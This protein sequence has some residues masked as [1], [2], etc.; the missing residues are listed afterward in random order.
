MRNLAAAGG[1]IVALASL[2]VACGHRPP[3]APPAS[4]PHQ[5]VVTAPNQVV[6]APVHP[7]PRVGAIFLGVGDLHACTGS[8][9]HSAA[10]HLVLTAAHC[11][12]GAGAVPF[13]AG[14]A[15]AAAPC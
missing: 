6:A 1:S 9:L 10:G 11:L 2:L 7:D 12:P 15:G 13:S 5:S 3:P 4:K 14:F 8:V